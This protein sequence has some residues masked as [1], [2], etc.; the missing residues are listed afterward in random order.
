MNKA[1]PI[2]PAFDLLGY[3]YP[4]LAAKTCYV[5]ACPNAE[6]NQF[7]LSYRGLDILLLVAG[8]FI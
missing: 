8:S 5:Y 4:P 7:A 6:A 3:N 1:E 2:D